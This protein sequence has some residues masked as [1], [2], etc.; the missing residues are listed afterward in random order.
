MKLGKFGSTV[1]LA[2]AST[3]AAAED[4][5]GW[6]QQVG[7][8]ISADTY[9]ACSRAREMAHSMAYSSCIGKGGV[10]EEYLSDCSE[11]KPTGNSYEVTVKVTYTCF[12]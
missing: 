7:W 12:R 1:A 6:K 9:A 11:P 10:S 5:A 3:F 2:L 4:Q 8:G